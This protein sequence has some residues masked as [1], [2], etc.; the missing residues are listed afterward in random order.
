MGKITLDAKMKIKRSTITGE[1][2]A[3]GPSNDHT[4]GTWSATDIYSGELFLNETD[5]RLWVGIDTAVVE[6]DL[7]GAV[8]AYLPLAG[9]AMD[10]SA[11]I[12]SA[13]GGGQLDLDT[14]GT[15]DNVLITTDNGAY[16]EGWID[17][18]P[19][20][21]SGGAVN[22]SLILFDS[23]TST[24]HFKAGSTGY[25]G[26]AFFRRG[27][28]AEA[29]SNAIYQAALTI[30]NNI[31]GSS[32]VEQGLFV[33]STSGATV[34]SPNGTGLAGAIL[35]S[36]DS[37]VIASVTNS[38]IL[39]GENITASADNTAYMQDSVNTGVAQFAEYTVAALPTASSYPGG[40]IMVT[41]EV[42][43][44]VPAFSDG[45]NWRRVTDR[46]IVS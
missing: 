40:Q 13:N 9:G 31:G 29:F 10:A 24:S 34:Y 41:D 12:T 4:D 26:G 30:K 16:A 19:T 45:T 5:A 39:G 6:L 20:Y 37:K 35:C 15:A 17:L 3:I 28:T 36:P 42:G 25:T 22:S 14:G 11:S 23:T 33:G 27:I 2:P 7:T 38:V 8:G 21:F 1:V 32:S 44:Y 18:S 43:G 46:A